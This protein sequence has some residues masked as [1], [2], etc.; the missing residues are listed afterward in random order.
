MRK[1]FVRD[2][3]A[4]WEAVYA[5][6]SA[7]WDIGRPQA[8]FVG[9]ADAGD[10]RS[11]VL[12]SGCGTG[13]HALM[14]AA[15]GHEVVGIDLSPTAIERARHKAAERGVQARFEVADVLDLGA[16][17]RRFATI[18]DNGVFHVFDDEDRARYVGSLAEAI[19]PGGVL[20]LMCFSEHTPGV[21][22]PRRVTQAELRQAFSDGWQVER[23]EAAEIEVR[24][25]WAPGPAKAWLARIVRA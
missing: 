3:V 10:I 15:R 9:L 16:L 1:P 22:G 20:H 6:D 23:I 8:A 4:G 21:T 2:A 13:E 17:K 19:E 12:D 7:P 14:L 24:P 5:D 25:D 18:V 11:P